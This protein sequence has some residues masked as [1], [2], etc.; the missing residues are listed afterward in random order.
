ME[1][2]TINV[3][4][5]MTS[6]RNVIEKRHMRASDILA[7]FFFKIFKIFYLFIFCFRRCI[8]LLGLP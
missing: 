5:V 7:T 6:K 8:S 3:S 1:M 2:I 4:I